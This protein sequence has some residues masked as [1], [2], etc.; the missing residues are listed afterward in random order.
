MDIPTLAATCQHQVHPAVIETIIEIESSG[1]PF[2]M[3]VVGEPTLTQPISKPDAY[4]LLDTLLSAGKNVSAGLMQINQQH[5]DVDTPIFDP[6]TNITYGAQLLKDCHDRAKRRFRRKPPMVWLEATAS[7][8]F[9]GNFT[10]GFHRP[11]GNPYVTRF[12][13]A[14]A[15][16]QHTLAPLAHAQP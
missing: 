6:C 16:H 5:F 15:R 1:Q 8:Y 10:T 13:L 11:K 4:A 2:A 12:R 3:A 14:Y 7:C 9:S